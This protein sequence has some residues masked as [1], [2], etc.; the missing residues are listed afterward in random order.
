MLALCEI[1]F[2]EEAS[3][4]VFKN[5]ICAGNVVMSLDENRYIMKCQSPIVEESL[6]RG[7]P[8]RRNLMV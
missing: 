4:M 3:D 6:G 1:S 5:D 2:V 7:R 8:R